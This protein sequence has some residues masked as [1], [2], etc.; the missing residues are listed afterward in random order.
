MT[1]NHPKLGFVGLGNMGGNMAARLLGAGYVVHGEDRAGGQA[2]PLLADGLQWCQ[3]AREVATV[4]DVVFTSLPDDDVIER[5][6]SAKDGILAGLR[7]GKLWVDVSTISPAKSRELAERVRATGASMLDAPVSGSVPQVQSG[8][9]TIMVGGEKDAYRRIE[10]ILRVLGTPSYIGKNGQGLA[11]KLAINISL[12]VQMLALCEG[13]LLA[14]RSGV[15]PQR[16][17]E[18]MESSQIGSPMLRARE[19]LILNP[20]TDDAWFDLAFMRKDIEL[21]LDT[22]AT[23]GIPLPTAASADD[24]LRR[25]H[26]LGYDRRDLASLYEVLDRIAEADHAVSAA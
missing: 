15:D 21:A 24:V 10:P 3:S 9:L 16:A 4:S 5:V 19:S 20:P 12:A 6:A 17:L 22:A 1:A 8:T 14:T 23:L 7:E 25:S 11:L 13:L 26:D 18:V 2:E